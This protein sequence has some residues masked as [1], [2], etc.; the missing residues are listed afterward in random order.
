MMPYDGCHA[1][2]RFWRS[3]SY[4]T[5]H[6]SSPAPHRFQS[7]DCPTDGLA[8]EAMRLGVRIE[9]RR[10]PSGLCGVYYEPARLIILDESMPD[11]QRRST[12]C[13]ELVHA[14]YHD[15][16]CG[17][18]YGAKAERRARRET[19]LRLI[20]PI[21]YATAEE[22]HEGDAYRIAC[23]LDVTLQVVEDYRR[24]LRDTI[25]GVRWRG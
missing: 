23:E 13:H 11:F 24:L 19:A 16:G 2:E 6:S 4:G 20:D 1:R 5:S 25:G 8:D 22:L 3:E 12:L 18:S 10:L 9:E 17:T 15:S 14:R 21:E 7:C